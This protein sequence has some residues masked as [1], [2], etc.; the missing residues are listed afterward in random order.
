MRKPNFFIVG[1]TRSGTSSL[2]YQLKQHPDV[3]IIH[4][5]TGQLHSLFGYYL[6]LIKSEK[7]Y[8][9]LFSLRSFG[10]SLYHSITDSCLEDGYKAI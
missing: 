6:P 1:H 7:E 9:R 10:E 3:F 8:L 5:G 4:T 2:L